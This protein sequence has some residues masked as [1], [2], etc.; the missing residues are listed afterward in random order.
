MITKRPRA[1]LATVV[2]ATLLAG[3][4]GMSET[5]KHTWSAVGGAAAGG[6]LGRAVAGKKNKT[7]GTVIGAVA[8]GV[9]GYAISGGFGG[10]ASD[11]QRAS[12]SFQQAGREFDAGVQ[13]KNSGDDAA[14]L[15]HY[16]NAQRI[17]PEQPEPYNNAGLI[18]LEQGD[19]TNAEAM[20]RKALEVDP[21]CQA[22]KDNLRKMGL[23][24]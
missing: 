10:S 23:S 8:G 13:A 4:E 2:A 19:R 3:C 22:A 6:L 1:I 12:P 24:G 7:A 16:R 18:Y 17:E 21:N 5:E 15:D 20:F 14:A 11:A 9:A